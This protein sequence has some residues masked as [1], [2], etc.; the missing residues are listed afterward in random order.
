VNQYEAGLN[1][2][3]FVLKRFALV[4]WM[5]YATYDVTAAKSN[6]N[7][8]SGVD[9]VVENDLNLFFLSYPKFRYGLDF[10]VKVIGLEV[11]IGGLLGTLAN[12]NKSVDYI[13]D[14]SVTLSVSIEQKGN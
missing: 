7:S 11:R 10:A 2:S 13:Q 5:D 6:R 8:E 3:W 12:L 9:D 1:L 4:P 14:K